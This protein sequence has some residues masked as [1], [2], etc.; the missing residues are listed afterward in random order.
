MKIVAVIPA[1]NETKV[2]SL[3]IAEVRKF[4]DLV[5]VVNDCSE[6][7]TGF[8]ANQAGAVVLNHLVN[9]GQGA[10]LQTGIIYAIQQ[11]AD[12]V[13]T[14]DADNQFIP[15]EIKA[16]IKPIIVYRLCEYNSYLLE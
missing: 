16:I 7:Q 3:V 2:I 9:C 15:Y 13:V 12:V 4:V 11:G 1:Y 14:F 6:D 8:L 5:V 10:A